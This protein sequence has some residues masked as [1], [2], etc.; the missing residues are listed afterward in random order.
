MSHTLEQFIRFMTDS[1]GLERTFRLF[2]AITQILSSF[3]L[4]FEVLIYLLSFTTQ[5]PPSLAATHTILLALRQRLAL[6]RRFFRLFRCLESFHA[7][8]KLYVSLSPPPPPGTKAVPPQPRWVQTEAWLDVFGRTFNA[9]YL[10]LEASTMI[11]ALGVEGFAVWTP[12]WHRYLTIEAQRFW[13]FA[14]VCGVFSGLLKMLKVLA[15][16]PVPP[17]GQGY[18]SDKQQEA[19]GTTGTA[20]ATEKP[21]F[22]DDDGNENERWELRREQERL[23]GIVRDRKQGRVAWRREIRSKIR[24][25]GLGVVANA[26]DI[27]LPGSVVGW[28]KADAGTVGLAMFVTTILTGK[29]V[30]DRC[31]RE[32]AG[33]K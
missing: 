21:V 17:T 8:H 29:E 2:Q 12:E 25:L 32:V 16:T 14:L 15:Y 20:T 5:G 4:P 13:L 33:G 24:G 30:W 27:T 10:L 18:S 19:T 22:K 1:V 7:A 11:E 23:R 31:G 3:A 9:M 28:V 6:A 26:L